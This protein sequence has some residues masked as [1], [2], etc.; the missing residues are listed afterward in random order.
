MSMLKERG[1]DCQVHPDNKGRLI[2]QSSEL[3]Q[4]TARAVPQK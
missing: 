2:I 1:I 3:Q 4:Y